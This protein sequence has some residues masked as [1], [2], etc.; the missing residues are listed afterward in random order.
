MSN[1]GSDPRYFHVL[2]ADSVPA[3]RTARIAGA[4]RLPV[5]L[6]EFG[7]ETRDVLA[8]AGLRHDL[9]DNSDNTLAYP[10][11]E[12][13]MLAA[14]RLT[15]CDHIGL[16]VGQHARL[17]HMGVAGEIAL[18]GRTAG[19]GLQNLI[20]HFNLHSSATTVSVVSTGEFARMVYAIAETGMTDTRQLQI[21]GVAISFNILQDLLGPAW[22]PSVVTFATRAP[23][24]LRPFQKFFRAA[25]RFDSDESAIVFE[26][27]WLARPLPPVSA[28]FRRRVAAE[29][30]VRRSAI[31]QDFPATVRRVLRKQLV[32]GPR[33]MDELAALL[34]M[35]RRTLDRRLQRHGV[36]YGELLE[37]V[38]SDVARQL[39]GD[40]RLQVQQIAES[41]HFSSAANFATAFRRWTGVTPTEFRRGAG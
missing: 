17:A 9:L 24:N 36:T 28:E 40:T 31:L 38:K 20:E 13:L 34:G 23:S 19:Q 26:H 27:H 41:L 39:L 7:V 6:K 10:E 1:L 30:R 5:V 11:Y 16:L 15:A 4:M 33:S 35:H 14:E 29:V 37:A 21:G 3:Q 18:C 25:L 12:R 2:E 22:T 8:A 32:L